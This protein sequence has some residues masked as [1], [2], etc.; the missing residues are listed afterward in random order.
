[1]ENSFYLFKEITRERMFRNVYTEHKLFL[2]EPG[3]TMHE[4]CGYNVYHLS[5]QAVATC[6]TMVSVILQSFSFDQGN[7]TH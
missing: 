6:P 1:M 2:E 5:V 7:A 4:H 3:N